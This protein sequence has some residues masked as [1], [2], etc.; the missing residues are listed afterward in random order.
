MIDQMAKMYEGLT[1]QERG[2]LAYA[3]LLQGNSLERMRIESTM[4]EQYFL[5]LPTDYR[6][7]FIDL[8]NLTMSYA[9]AYWQQVA[10]CQAYMSAAR[11]LLQDDDPE[12]Y[13]PMMER[14]KA[15][16]A[17]LLAIEQAFDD[18]CAEHGL[19]AELMRQRK[20]H[21]FYAV[22]SP[23]VKADAQVIADY[24]EVFASALK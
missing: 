15:G 12:A 8:T 21:Q 14:F 7:V 24:R 9:V 20:G 2:K 11:V 16:E 23:D 1:D 4:Q 13:K 17:A 5:G 19:N 3:Y 18:V 6:R 22:A 10:H